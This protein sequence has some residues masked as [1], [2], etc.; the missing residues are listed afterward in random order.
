MHK[1]I[2]LL[3]TF[4][5]VSCDQ[6]PHIPKPQQEKED[7]LV[8]LSDPLRQKYS[9]TSIHY[10]NQLY[11]LFLDKAPEFKEVFTINRDLQV[12]SIKR[13]DFRYEYLW[14]NHRDRIT[15]SG[16]L[17][18][19]SN[20]DWTEKD[21]Q[22]LLTQSLSYQKLIQQLA[23]LK[24]KNQGH[25]MWPEARKKFQEIRSAGHMK[26]IEKQLQEAHD[27]VSKKLED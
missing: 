7:K 16:N 17:S 21:E 23:K 3:I 25:S 10:Q 4:F 24:E 14:K 12:A 27:S 6:K 9:E 15:T 8:T 5:L 22:Q 13:R 20:F 19:W 18:E 26:E 1:L 2:C 11:K